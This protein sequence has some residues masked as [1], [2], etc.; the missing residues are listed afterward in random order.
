[1]RAQSTG[2]MAWT[3]ERELVEKERKMLLSTEY[4]DRA[5]PT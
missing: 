1:M 4:G 5:S 2:R 3:G